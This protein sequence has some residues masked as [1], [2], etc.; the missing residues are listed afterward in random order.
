MEAYISTPIK[1]EEESRAI[2]AGLE[3][4]GVTVNNPCDIDDAHRDPREIQKAVFDECVAM[5]DRSDIGVL[6]LDYFGRDCAWEIGYMTSQEMP[7][8]G[9]Y[10]NKGASNEESL[11]NLARYR[12]SLTGIFE[13]VDEL[14]ASL[15]S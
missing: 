8:Y 5:M 2:Q 3:S 9:V 7:I 10:V 15:K 14:V 13:S 6:I 12:P 4:I 11:R 1:R